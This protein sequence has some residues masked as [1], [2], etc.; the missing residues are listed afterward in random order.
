MS[1]FHLNAICGLVTGA[2]IYSFRVDNLH[3][4]AYRVANVLGSNKRDDEEGQEN[5]DIEAGSVS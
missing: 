5:M 3:S 2:K 1:E 4:D